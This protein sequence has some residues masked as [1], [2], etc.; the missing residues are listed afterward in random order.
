MS[1]KQFPEDFY[2]LIKESTDLSLGSVVSG[3]N[4]ELAH[5]RIQ[6]FK[7]GTIAA[8]TRMRLS[9]KSNEGAS[10]AIAVSDWANTS[11]ITFFTSGDWLGRVRFDFARQNISEDTTYYVY[12]ETENYTRNADTDYLGVAYDWPL[13]VNNGNGILIE[14]FGNE[15]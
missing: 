3:N 13:K 14:L 2:I 7:H 10:S 6:L 8:N 11:D 9:I 15:R 1:L 12:L 4:L 5:I